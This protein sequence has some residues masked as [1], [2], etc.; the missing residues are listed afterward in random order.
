MTNILITGCAGFIGSHVAELFVNS[1]YNVIGYDAF[2]YAGKEENLKSIKDK[3]NF[4]CYMD[5]ITNYETLKYCIKTNDINWIINLAA[6]THVDNSI[7]DCMPFISTNIV[8]VKT[9]L[10]I[11]K[12]TKCKL[13]HFSTD[14]VYGVAHNISFKETDCLNPRNPYSATKASADHLI[15]SYANTYGINYILVR[16]SNNFGPR[17]H[18][19]KFVPTI[20]KNLK[21]NNKIP[22]YGDG[23]QIREWT[24]VRETAKAIKFI[25]ENSSL[26]EIYNISSNCEMTNMNVVKSVC[27]LLNLT[28]DK[29]VQ[30][31]TDR[32]GH[33]IKYSVSCDKLTSLGFVLKSNFEETLK[34]ILKEN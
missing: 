22:I 5:C 28:Y 7:K 32:P 18:N 16:P 15:L 17:Q 30:Y 29:C 25:L 23:S 6:E 34:D 31:I 8:G 11:C 33:D 13:L 1:G 9:I 19:E 3:S 14:E 26:N 20:I 10:D 4:K 24:D 12:E 2:T 27:S 21:N